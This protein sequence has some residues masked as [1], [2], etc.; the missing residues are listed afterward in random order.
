[1]TAWFLYARFQARTP[2]QPTWGGPDYISRGSDL[3]SASFVEVVIRT[4]IGGA[5][6]T[7]FLVLCWHWFIRRW[8][9]K[10]T[11]PPIVGERES[12]LGAA[13]GD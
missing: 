3:S 11:D 12:G 13:F 2:F 1:M 5:L 8:W 9:E 7:G 10:G 6:F 4:A